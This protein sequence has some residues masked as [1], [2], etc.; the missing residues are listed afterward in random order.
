LSLREE[1]AQEAQRQRLI[2]QHKTIFSHLMQYRKRI[3]EDGSTDWWIGY[4]ADTI[5]TC[6]VKLT[7]F[8]PVPVK[9]A[10]AKA[11]QL[12]GGV[13]KFTVTG[14]FKNILTL[15]GTLENRQCLA[16]VTQ[17]SITKGRDASTLI[18]SFSVG[19]LLAQPKPGKRAERKDPESRQKSPPEKGGEEK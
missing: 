14:S 2:K 8:K 5:R 3:P 13:F 17:V 4:L 19:V 18:A 1:L 16:R 15:I 6:Q 10:Q 12:A 9:S 11:G 7:E